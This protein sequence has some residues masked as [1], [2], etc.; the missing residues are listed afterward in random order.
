MLYF[1]SVNWFLCSP[2]KMVSNF[3]FCGQL[4]SGLKTTAGV[5]PSFPVN[6]KYLLDALPQQKGQEG[7]ENIQIRGLRSPDSNRN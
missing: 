5:L 3:T 6:V 4:K 1:P 2:Q 7:R